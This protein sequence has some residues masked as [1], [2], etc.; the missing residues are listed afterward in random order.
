MSDLQANSIT[1]F[2]FIVNDEA[3]LKLKFAKAVTPS[4]QTLKRV[5]LTFVIYEDNEDPLAG[6]CEEL[7][8]IS[9]KNRLESIGI[10][11]NI[12]ADEDCYTGD[13]WGKLER[14]LLQPGWP[15]LKHVSLSIIIVVCR[16]YFQENDSPLKVAL[17]HLRETQFA[18]L[19]SSKNLDF[20]FSICEVEP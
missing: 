17:E 14:V 13:T 12:H 7:E 11:I 15:M 19:M 20:Q 1:S 2:V 3:F 8:E 10:V 16:E 9:G 4:L 6:L 5:H 18:R